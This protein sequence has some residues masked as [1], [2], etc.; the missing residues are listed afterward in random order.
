MGY[1]YAQPR[2]PEPAGQEG[3]HR[4]LVT[5]TWQFRTRT[6]PTASRL[7]AFTLVAALAISTR[8]E[9][10]S[11]WAARL[12]RDAGRIRSR[13]TD[14]QIP[15]RGAADAKGAAPRRRRRRSAITR[16]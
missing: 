14:G 1:I 13:R 15:T 12:N 6:G 9:L 16:T 8:I 2:Q 7:R 11:L 10:E 5:S 3:S 4:R